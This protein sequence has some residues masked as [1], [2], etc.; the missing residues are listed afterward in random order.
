MAA[1]KRSLSGVSAEDAPAPKMAKTNTNWRDVFEIDIKV[2]S[3]E[4]AYQN[5]WGPIDPAHQDSY[6]DED[7]DEEFDESNHDGYHEI[8]WLETINGSALSIET[9]I[10]KGKPDCVGRCKSLLIRRSRIKR[11]FHS[12]MG[13]LFI[14]T[15][16]M[17]LDLFNRYGQLR[18]AF[19]KGSARSGSGIWGDELDDGDILMIQ[20][21]WIDKSHRRQGM[22]QEMIRDIL[23][24]ALAK[25]NPQTFIAIARAGGK[26]L[27]LYNHL[28][29]GRET[30]EKHTDVYDRA[31]RQLEG[32]WRSLGFR[33]IGYTEWFA[34]LPGDAQHACHSLPA[35]EDFDPPT[36]DLGQIPYAGF[37]RLLE[38]FESTKKDAARLTL[39]Q[40]ALRSYMP[41]VLYEPEEDDSWT[42]ADRDGNTLLHHAATSESPACVKWMI[43]M[44]PRLVSE[45][46]FLGETPLDAC[47]ERLEAIRTQQKWAGGSIT[48]SDK[49]TGYSQPYVEILCILKGL[50]NLSLEELLRLKYGCTCG[51]CQEGFF[52]PRMRMALQCSA[53]ITSE[54]LLSGIDETNGDEFFKEFG[55]FLKYLRP[56]MC[57]SMRTDG[58]L[59]KGFSRMFDHFAQYLRESTE[60]PRE[61][62]VVEAV[63][64][65]ED[66]SSIAKHYLDCGGTVEAVGSALFK[67]LMDES[68]SAGDGATWDCFADDLEQL[69]ACR[70]DEEFGFVSSMCGYARVRQGQC[71]SASGCPGDENDL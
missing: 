66:E 17:G 32:F 13:E 28:G 44:C 70:N 25:C 46:N 42:S 20:R 11:S 50:S 60:P 69:P 53:G 9:A 48:V 14:D 34:F 71:F 57:K 45:R 1:L 31:R 36:P 4:K 23:Q 19:K 38:A 12:D 27:E 55:S 47:Q 40:E 68:L 43:E 10:D 30:S 62:K 61:L 15:S 16:S 22:G 39:I 2:P 54:M 8:D 35:D 51:Q 59:R 21:M 6:E 5:D 7:E 52:S 67:R 29:V 65:E 37:T 58:R 26:W 49:F 3:K 64:S 41:G 33:R 63:I 24:R 56:E 18:P